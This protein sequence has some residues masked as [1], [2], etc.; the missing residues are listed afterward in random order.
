LCWLAKDD[1]HS[2]DND[3]TS[4]DS[5]GVLVEHE[6]TVH[7]LRRHHISIEELDSVV[8]KEAIWSDLADDDDDDDDDSRDDDDDE[9]EGEEEDGADGNNSDK[10]GDVMM[11]LISIFIMLILMSTT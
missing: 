1:D 11:V 9:E 6:E 3:L 8:L 10:D 7:V 4:T 5:E 2:D